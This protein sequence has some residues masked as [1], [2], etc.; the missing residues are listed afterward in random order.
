MQNKYEEHIFTFDVWG[1]YI[2]HAI[3]ISEVFK[4]KNRDVLMIGAGDTIFHSHFITGAGLNR[5]FDF[6]VKCANLLTNL[7]Y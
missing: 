3:K 7:K 2:R 4:V 1:I 6:S 5:I